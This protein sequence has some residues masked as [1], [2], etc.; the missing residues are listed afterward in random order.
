MYKFAAVLA[1]GQ[2]FIEE[3][4]I[5]EGIEYDLTH[6][7][8]WYIGEYH[9]FNENF[10]YEEIWDDN[11]LMWKEMLEKLH[12]QIP[13]FI[14]VSKSGT[15][16][17]RRPT[18]DLGEVCITIKGLLKPDITWEEQRKYSLE[19]T[20]NLLFDNLAIW[21]MLFEVLLEDKPNLEESIND[22]NMFRQKNSRM[23]IL[24]LMISAK[25]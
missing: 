9:T 19:R 18:D 5:N 16:F 12:M 4:H 15:T 22:C 7:L 14:A 1:I 13:Q 8:I 25:R 17:C 20:D 21:K 24:M 11:N 3:N 10:S 2:D 23:K 6:S